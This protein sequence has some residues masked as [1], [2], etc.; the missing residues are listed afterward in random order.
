MGRIKRHIGLDIANG[1]VHSRDY[2]EIDGCKLFYQTAGRASDQ[3]LLFFHGAAGSPRELPVLLEN[4]A[5]RGFY[6]IAPEHPGMG[7]SEHLSSYAPDLFSAYGEIYRRLLHR[8]QI[9]APIVMAQSFGGGPA[10]ALMRSAIE[11]PLTQEFDPRALV[12]VDCFIAQAPER[13]GLS[14]F[15]GFLLS[16]LG[17]AL[18]V[19]SRTWRHLL[20]SFLS[21]KPREYFTDVPARDAEFATALGSLFRA[22][23]RGCPLVRLDYARFVT[24]GAEPR[25]L[26]LVWGEKDGTRLIDNAEWGAKVTAIADAKALFMRVSEEVSSRI[27]PEFARKNVRMSVVPKAGHAGLHTESYMNRYLDELVAH[28]G[29]AGL[30]A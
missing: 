18:R 26:I 6:A 13:V 9:K 12:L 16:N 24:A 15:Y 2:C 10:H 3:A 30:Q 19:P 29:E 23:S 1:E 21:G 22:F 7:R 25:P 8:L 11:K 4:L 14:G 5:R 28:L 20:T 17:P 27:S